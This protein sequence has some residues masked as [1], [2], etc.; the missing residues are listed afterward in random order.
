MERYLNI[1]YFLPERRIGSSQ[2]GDFIGLVTLL[3]KYRGTKL[4]EYVSKVRT[5]KKK[6]ENGGSLSFNE[7]MEQFYEFCGWFS[8]NP[9]I[10][11]VKMAKYF[12]MWLC[13][14]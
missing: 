2:N 1:I 6:Q 5:H 10:E 8:Q 7:N 13:S 9:I 12:Q 4:T 3:T 14:I 11:A